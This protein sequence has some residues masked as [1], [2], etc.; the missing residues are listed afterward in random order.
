MD[1]INEAYQKDINEA[2]KKTVDQDE[3]KKTLR[4]LKKMGI[5]DVLKNMDRPNREYF[6]KFKSPDKYIEFQTDNI[7][8]WHGGVMVHGAA[9]DPEPKNDNQLDMSAL[10]GWDGKLDQI[11][12]G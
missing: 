1:P 8:D 11:E 9:R 12:V 7:I 10:I 5:R 4:S 6:K 2:T 3:L